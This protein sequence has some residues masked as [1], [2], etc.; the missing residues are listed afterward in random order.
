[1]LFSFHHFVIAFIL[2]KE[3]KSRQLRNFVFCYYEFSKMKYH[4]GFCN[5]VRLVKLIRMSGV[6]REIEISV[7][8]L[9]E[10]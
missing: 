5:M 10:R 4:Y 7:E 6:V 2:E 3:N 9:Q 8:G 1:M